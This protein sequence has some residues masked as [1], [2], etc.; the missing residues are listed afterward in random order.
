MEEKTGKDHDNNL[1]AYFTTGEFARLCKVKKQTLFHYD[2]IGIFSPEI[3]KDNGYRYY[4]YNQLEVFRVISVLKEMDMPL[5]NIKA[6][7]DNRSPGDLIDLLEKQI[8]EIDKKLGDLAWLKDFLKTKIHITKNALRVKTGAVLTEKLA[9]DEY[10]IATPYNDTDDDK[11]IAKAITEH[12]NYCHGLDIY[13]AYSIGGMIPAD[14]PPTEKYYNYSHFYTKLSRNEYHAANSRKPG[15]SY[16]V[17]YHR[18]GYDTVHLDYAAL[19]EYIK[20]HGYTMGDYFYED[21]I[22][23]ELSM[24]GYENYVLKISVQCNL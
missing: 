11:K 24:K 17:I 13:S 6:Y 23:D 5:K 9:A 22:L 3:K 4:S 14:R 8:T 10:L 16:A 12:I 18:G 2:D 20:A 21:V 19:A 7:L 1:E 15:G